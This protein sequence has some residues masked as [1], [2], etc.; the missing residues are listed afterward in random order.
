[1][2][3]KSEIEIKMEELVSENNF[4]LDD[5]DIKSEIEMKMEELVSENDFSL[6]DQ[7][8][9]NIESNISV[10]ESKKEELDQMTSLTIK[11][12]AGESEIEFG[13]DEEQVKNDVR[14]SENPEMITKF[15]N[16]HVRVY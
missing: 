14:K 2:D 3:I 10:P 15:N 9:P 13:I 16:Q 8:F 6:D 1:M 7:S 12:E 4:S 5:Q 11:S